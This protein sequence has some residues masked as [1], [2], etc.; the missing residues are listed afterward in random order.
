MQLAAHHAT[1]RTGH[2]MRDRY[3]RYWSGR[4]VLAVVGRHNL[5]LQLGRGQIAN[6]RA[7]LGS[8]DEERHIA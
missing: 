6:G 1:R 7:P 4:L 3:L 5:L 2:R 8:S